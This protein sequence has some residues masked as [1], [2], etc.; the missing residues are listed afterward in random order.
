MPQKI[1]SIV[2]RVTWNNLNQTSTSLEAEAHPALTFLAFLI[3]TQ[4]KWLKGKI[5]SYSDSTHF[6]NQI[7]YIA[8]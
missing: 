5:T 4:E 1:E 2:R 6:S 3:H 7:L 8:R